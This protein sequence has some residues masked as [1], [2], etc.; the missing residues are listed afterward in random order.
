MEETADLRQDEG[1]IKF[2]AVPYKVQSLATG[3]FRVALDLTSQ[4][5]NAAMLLL[6]LA[7]TPGLLL[8]ITAEIE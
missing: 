7:D 5:A 1:R 8:R 3:G 6:R 4:D 2:T